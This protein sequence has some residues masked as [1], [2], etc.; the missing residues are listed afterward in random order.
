MGT[1]AN[2]ELMLYFYIVFK[3]CKLKILTLMY[4]IQIVHFPL[5]GFFRDIG[6]SKVNVFVKVI[7]DHD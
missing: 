3:T 1:K 7:T 2:K 5:K 6:K 4:L